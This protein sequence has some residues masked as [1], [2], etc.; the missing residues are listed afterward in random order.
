MDDIQQQEPIFDQAVECEDLFAKQITAFNDEGDE[1][2]TKILSDI[3]QRFTSWAAFLGVFAESNVCLDR[4]LRRHIDIQDQVLRLLDIMREN[5]ACLSE[6]QSSSAPHEAATSDPSS[7]PLLV[8]PQSLDAISAALDRLCQLGTAIRRSSVT[9]QVSKARELAETFDLGSFE[10]LAYMLLRTHYPDASSPLL[11]QLTR[12]MVESYALFLLRR[13]RK[14]RLSVART[15][16]TPRPYLH[17]I[18]EERAD[19]S[20]ASC[21]IAPYPEPTHED[22]RA[23]AGVSQPIWSPPMQLVPQSEPTSLDSQE[24][25]ARLRR[26]LNPS[27]KSKPASILG[28]RAC[29]PRPGKN[30]LTCDWCFEPIM[31]DSLE[32][33]KWQHHI[34]DDF[35][36][37]VCV[38][39]KC[40]QSL[41]RFASSTEWFQHMTGEHGND[42]HRDVH[43]P[44]SWVCPLCM[45]EDAR[46]PG[47]ESLSDHIQSCHSGTFSDQ[48]VKAIVR[49]SKFASPRPPSS[50]PLC[51]FPIVDPQAQAALPEGKSTGEPS[52]GQQYISKPGK[53]GPKRLRIDTS[54]KQPTDRAIDATV[55]A[56]HMTA[57]LQNIMLLTLRLM[58]IEAPSDETTQSQSQVSETD[59]QS[60]WASSEPRDPNTDMPDDPEGGYQGDDDYRAESKGSLSPLQDVPDSVYI[61]WSHVFITRDDTPRAESRQTIVQE[62]LPT[63]LIPPGEDEQQTWVRL[64]TRY[65]LIEELVRR[66]QSFASYLTT[67]AELVSSKEFPECPSQDISV[68]FRNAAPLAQFSADF[69]IDL[70]R[71]AAS[72]FHGTAWPPAGNDQS[73]GAGGSITSAIENDSSTSIGNAFMAQ[74]CLL[75]EIYVRCLQNQKAAT[76]SLEELK[77][78]VTEQ[79]DS[80][81]DPLNLEGL[82]TFL[83]KPI[84]HLSE[85]PNLLKR[86]LD[87][88]PTV[89]P[90]WAKLFAARFKV[91]AIVSQV[92]NAMDRGIV[93]SALA[94]SLPSGWRETSEVTSRGTQGYIGMFH[95]KVRAINELVS[96]IAA[97]V[98]VTDRFV[99]K[100]RHILVAFRE[101]IDMSETDDH[102]LPDSLGKVGTVVGNVGLRNSLE[103]ATKVDVLVVEPLKQVLSLYGRP[104]VL[105]AHGQRVPNFI[106]LTEALDEELPRLYSLT[107]RV[108]DMCLQRLAHLQEALNKTMYAELRPL[109]RE[110]PGSLEHLV[111]DWQKD[112]EQVD[113]QVRTLAMC[114]GYLLPGVPIVGYETPPARESAHQ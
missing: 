17:T 44:S 64:R 23:P 19:N 31:P 16:H 60:S 22:D 57:H 5:L 113:L 92:N 32:G 76:K 10:Q 7:R 112:L 9:S 93:N 37:Y 11:D 96:N 52:K 91:E 69:A 50:C 99:K 45:D 54:Q 104:A 46:F 18:R 21:L 73:R 36:P 74:N 79:S 33:L 59:N 77:D 34:S 35:K 106:A 97:S 110:T 65:Q 42:W 26:L 8:Y 28:N 98:K 56:A 87:H 39:E 94:G 53:S 80:L 12:S 30:T 107:E 4:R 43:A 25:K 109:A 62:L 38:S 78:W 48:Q 13:S 20:D 88:T 75:Q 72:V 84:R 89:H 85:Y 58:S 95:E 1:D 70:R 68:R 61:D 66:E 14:T 105:I 71:A 100:V 102:T 82:R 3:H 108:L 49:Q 101:L 15:Q 90:D 29:Y 111:G 2:A 86:L 47:S 63:M 67:I 24:F 51:C 103:Y 83:D 41:P 27:I 81:P 114:N 55:I 40:L 6:K